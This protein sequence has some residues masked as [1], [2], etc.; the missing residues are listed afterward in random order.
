M[1]KIWSILV[2]NTVDLTKIW[3]KIWSILSIWS[4]LINIWSML[5]FG[6]DNNVINIVI[7]P[8]GGGIVMLGGI[9]AIPGGIVIG[10]NEVGGCG[11]LLLWL[12]GMGWI[13]WGCGCR[14]WVKMGRLWC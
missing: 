7:W 8:W 3:S 4:I 1:V 10:V 11:D 5:W 2:A 9:R 6:F 12:F 14:C 13:C